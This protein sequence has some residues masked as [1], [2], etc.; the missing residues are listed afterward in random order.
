MS[1]EVARELSQSFDYSPGVAAEEVT[2]LLIDMADLAV[3]LDSYIPSKGI[4]AVAYAIGDFVAIGASP[5]LGADL[6]TGRTALKIVAADGTLI[7][8]ALM[9]K[10]I[11]ALLDPLGVGVS[12]ATLEG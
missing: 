1:P 4:G 2:V 10:D 11:A 3:V 8:G 7:G 6:P 9:V 12:L 5:P